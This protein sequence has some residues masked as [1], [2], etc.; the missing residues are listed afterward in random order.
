MSALAMIE[1]F[2]GKRPD[3]SAVVER[4]QVKVIEGKGDESDACELVKSPAFVQGIASG[5][6]IKLNKDEN[7]FELLK[8]SG[9]LCVR[10]LSK[11]PISP[12][13][14]DLIPQFEK[15]GGSI[16]FENERMLVFSIHV[17][18]GFSPVEALLNEYID[19]ELGSMWVYGNVY[20]PA[21]GVTPLKWWLDI[22]KPQ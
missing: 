16:D 10:V 22:L 12:L 21:D 15:L 4:L 19:E 20:D 6:L 17:S 5:D 11:E 8:R 9:N 3:G 14:Q 2:A 13:A 7:T 18:C 1:L